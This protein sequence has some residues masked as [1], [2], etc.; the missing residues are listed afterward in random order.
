MTKVKSGVVSAAAVLLAG[1]TWAMPVQPAAGQATLFTGATPTGK[2]VLSVEN[3]RNYVKSQKRLAKAQ[4]VTSRRQGPRKGVAPSNR[5]RRA[6]RRVQK[7]HARVTNQRRDLLHNMTTRLVKDFDVIVVEDLNIK[8]MVK[9]KHLAKHIHDAAWAEF[10]RQ[11]NYKAVWYGATVVKADRFYPSSKT[12]SGCG[13]VKAKLSLSER[14]YCC[15]T[16]GVSVDRDVNAAINLARLGE[17]SGANSTTGG[18]GSAGTRSV[19]GRGGLRKT[20]T[21]P[22]KSSLVGAVAGEASTLLTA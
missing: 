16:C 13:E 5:W 11:L 15:D 21:R 9:N 8:G 1:S 14:T 22:E 18:Q 12:C 4:R 20:S 2:Q 7:C 10:I 6:N 17:T 3:P 19:A